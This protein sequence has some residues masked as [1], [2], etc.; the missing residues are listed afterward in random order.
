MHCENSC[1][2]LC[3]FVGRIGIHVQNVFRNVGEKVLCLFGFLWPT[4]QTTCETDAVP[5]SGTG[6]AMLS[7]SASLELPV[8][9]YDDVEC[10]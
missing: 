4:E 10:R 2:L 6:P 1:I 3:L 9:R 5:V 8:H 7:C